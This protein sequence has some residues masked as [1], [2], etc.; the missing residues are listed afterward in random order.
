MIH[1]YSE[2]YEGMEYVEMNVLDMNFDSQI[3]DIVI[4]KGTIDSILCSEGSSQ[5]ALQCVKEINRVLKNNGLFFC[6]SYGI[7]DYRS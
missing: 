5:N 7:P 6:V 1:E 3:F 4:D 2:G